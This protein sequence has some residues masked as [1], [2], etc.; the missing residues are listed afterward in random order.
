MAVLNYFKQFKP[1]DWLSLANLGTNLVGG[2]AQGKQAERQAGES[3]QDYALRLQQQAYQQAAEAYQ[4]KLAARSGVGSALQDQILRR[5]SQASQTVNAMPLGAEQDLVRQMARLRGLSQVSENFHPLMATDPNIANRVRPTTNALAALT[6]PEYRASISPEATA[7]SIAERRKAIGGMNPEFKF[8]NM[9]DYGIPDLG[10]EVSGYQEIQ[11]NNAAARE[12]ALMSLLLDQSREASQPLQVNPILPPP[13][14]NAPAPSAP[15]AK[16]GT[17]WWKKV[18]KVASIAAPIIAAPFTGGASL[19]AIGAGAGAANGAL[20]GGWKGAALGAGL[21][22]A[23]AGIGGGAAGEG[24]KRAVGETV[25]SAVKRAVLNPRALAQ[26]GGAAIPGAAGAA[27]QGAST[28]LPGAR[29][30]TGGPQGPPNPNQFSSGPPAMEPYRPQPSIPTPAGVSVEDIMAQLSPISRGT[31]VNIPQP[32]ITAGRPVQPRQG[33]HPMEIPPMAVSHGSAG[34]APTQFS[35]QPPMPPIPAHSSGNP[36]IRPDGS[37]IVG[38]PQSAQY[39]GPR[40]NGNSSMGPMGPRPTPVPSPAPATNPFGNGGGTV[41]NLGSIIGGGSPLFPPMPQRPPVVNANSTL[42]PGSSFQMDA[43]PRLDQFLS[44][45]QKTFG[46][47][48]TPTLVVQM[49]Q[50]TGRADLIPLY[51]SQFLTRGVR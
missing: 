21:G 47:Q 38:L 30:Y 23:T 14:V 19:L 35:A 15:E 10:K 9:G 50:K 18:I 11:G 48:L 24:A 17:P 41:G 44:A 39:T 51:R 42:V 5:E 16:K 12:N 36:N 37:V 20:N 32:G 25:G 49:L 3:A 29:S 26:I 27:V 31:A 45:L 22:A 7:R 8:G 28:F 46:P 13:D 2:F 43:K 33:W 4:R 1:E 40:V 6:T 34:Q